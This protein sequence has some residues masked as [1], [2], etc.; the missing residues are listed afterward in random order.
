MIS[1]IIL[2]ISLI[3]RLTLKTRCNQ[4]KISVSQALIE[5]SGVRLTFAYLSQSRN[6]SFE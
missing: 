1:P 4:I 5:K 2:M 3:K 6:G